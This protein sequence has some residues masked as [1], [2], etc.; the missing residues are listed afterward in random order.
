MACIIKK[1]TEKSKGVITFTT[2]ERDKVFAVDRD[3]LQSL[4]EMKDRWVV[5]LHHNWHDYNF[6]YNPVFDFSM[7]G[8]GDLG[9]S[10]VPLIP[11]DA[12]NFIQPPYFSEEP[13]KKY[14]MF[15]M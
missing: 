10:E 12:C 13:T 14:G 1:P 5:G 4:I 2:Q 9:S 3:S 7:A 6:R 15:Y 11:L 8:P